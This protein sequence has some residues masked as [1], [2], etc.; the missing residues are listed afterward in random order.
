LDRE[1]KSQTNI[2]DL[3]RR[4]HGLIKF[5]ERRLLEN[6]LL[7]PGA[8][9]FTLNLLPSFAEKQVDDSSVEAWVGQKAK[10]KE[11]A[12]KS[13]ILKKSDPNWI[14]E[15]NAPKLLSDLF[16]EL[17]EH[18]ETFDKMRDCLL[19]TDW[20]LENEPDEL[21]ELA[22]YLKDLTADPEGYSKDGEQL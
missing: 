11:Y 2:D 20:I 16:G 4:S 12:G 8:I 22:G 6:Y 18:Q 5:I 1:D 19:L 21:K 13:G 9:A 7:R 3:I 14:K 15:I 17:S 10:R